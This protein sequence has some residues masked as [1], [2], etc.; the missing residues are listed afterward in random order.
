MKPPKFEKNMYQN[1]KVSWE[2]TRQA[3]LLKE[4]FENKCKLSMFQRLCVNMEKAFSLFSEK[5]CGSI[6]WK[7]VCSIKRH[8]HFR[9]YIIIF[10]KCRYIIPFFYPLNK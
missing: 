7:T 10:L 8:K 4:Q 5:A 9:L 1:K 6:K 3:I 2:V